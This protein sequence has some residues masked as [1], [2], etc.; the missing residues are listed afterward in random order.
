MELDFYFINL[1]ENCMNNDPK[2]Q[3]DLCVGV[4][5]HTNTHKYDSE[6]K[7]YKKGLTSNISVF[8][9]HVTVVQISF[10]RASKFECHLLTVG[11]RSLGLEISM[12]GGLCN[13]FPGDFLHEWSC[14]GKLS[15]SS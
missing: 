10:L 14:R 5:T 4:Y 9:F 2:Y 12:C 3:A 13:W 15:C 8:S 11:C 6:D 1:T 7:N